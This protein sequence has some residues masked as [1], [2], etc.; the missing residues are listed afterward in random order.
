MNLSPTMPLGRLVLIIVTALVLALLFFSP[1]FW[2]MRE[3]IPGSFQWSRALG[4]LAQCEDPFRTDVEPAL[5]W[6]LLPPIVA[7]ALGLRGYW[8]LLLP[9]IGVVAATS[10]VAVLYRRRLNNPRWVFAG[11]L[12]FTTTSAV[13]APFGWLGINDAWV[14]LALLAV[15]F[16]QGRL[17]LPLACLLAPW[18]DERFVI[19]IPLAWLVRRFDRGEAW[20]ARDL[21]DGLWLLPYLGLRIGWSHFAASP[22]GVETSF[23]AAALTNFP[24]VAAH[25]PMGWWM[26]LRGAWLPVLFALI[27][28]RGQPLHTLALAAGG[29]TLIAGTVLASDLSRSVAIFTPAVLLGCF[30]AA[31]RYPAH[32]PSALLALAGANLFIP[33]A[34]VVFN[35]VSVIYTFP[36][37]LFRFLR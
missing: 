9:W 19:G 1:A 3:P 26:G 12:L 24:I 22:T 6:R 28:F 4:Y 2:L 13:I 17:A 33:A 8:A 18:I 29:G 21:R 11:A 10:Y 7:Q 27:V 32:A 15:A 5:R 30:A 20:Q 37:E 14:W 35:K 25:A 23:L 16:G 34:H 31:Q 36:V